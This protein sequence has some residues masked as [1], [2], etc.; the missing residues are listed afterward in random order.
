VKIT[1]NNR[2]SGVEILSIEGEDATVAKALLEAIK[3]G[4]DLGGADLYGADLYG[5]NLY[6]VNLR[7]ANLGCADLRGANLGGVNLR[8]AN[9]GGVNLYGADLDGADLYGA[10]LYGVNLYGVNLYGAKINGEKVLITPITIG[11]LYWWVLITDGYMRIGCQRHSHA[12]WAQFV[13]EAISDM[14]GHAL[15]FWRQWK[16]L[17]LAMCEQHHAAAVAKKETTEV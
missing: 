12:E 7:G 10:D 6:G 2:W 8:G 17:L 14:D 16:S 15:E 11:G 13:D 5:V 3:S 4:A 9:L 1:I